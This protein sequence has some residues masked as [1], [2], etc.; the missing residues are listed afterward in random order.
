MHTLLSIIINISVGFSKNLQ[1]M[2]H[3][4]WRYWDAYIF[5]KVLRIQIERSRAFFSKMKTRRVIRVWKLR[6][7][8]IFSV[9]LSLRQQF[10]S[11]QDESYII[12]L[13]NVSSIEWCNPKY[14]FRT[15]SKKFCIRSE[16]N[17]HFWDDP[18]RN[19][20]RFCLANSSP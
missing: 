7:S 2:S 19:S 12:Q 16:K 6:F 20:L 15:F 3:Q 18:L 9:N 14:I 5:W 10:W 8:W 1:M 13:R 17:I 11:V 4:I